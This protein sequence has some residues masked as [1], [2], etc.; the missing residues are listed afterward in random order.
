MTSLAVITRFAS[1]LMRQTASTLTKLTPQVSYIV[2]DQRVPSVNFLHTNMPYTDSFVGIHYQTEVDLPRETAI[3]F[4]SEQLTAY[5]LSP[6]HEAQPE[7]FTTDEAQT[8]DPC[9]NLNYFSKPPKQT[10]TSTVSQ[11]YEDFAHNTYK[12]EDDSERSSWFQRA[13]FSI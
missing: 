13:A 7:H 3:G 9:I 4:Q 12:V 6:Q 2:V 1:P 5:T 8:R 11:D 10:G